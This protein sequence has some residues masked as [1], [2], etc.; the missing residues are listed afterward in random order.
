[1]IPSCSFETNEFEIV[2]VWVSSHP[3]FRC[4]ALIW[5]EYL[6]D[7]IDHVS[8]T[9]LCIAVYMVNL[10]RFGVIFKS[11]WRSQMAVVTSGFSG[12]L[13]FPLAAPGCV[14][15]LQNPFEWSQQ[16]EW[17]S[18]LMSMLKLIPLFWRLCWHDQISDTGLE[19]TVLGLTVDFGSPWEDKWI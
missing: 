6:P 3:I 2:R 12:L 16:K 10:C 1:M 13:G 8:G 11:P 9:K 17:T 5:P 7:C 18:P 15:N 4:Q 14:A 19:L